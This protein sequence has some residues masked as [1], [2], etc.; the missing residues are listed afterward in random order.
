MHQ[1]HID[2]GCFVDDEQ[3]AVEGVLAIPP[4]AAGP[5]IDFEQAVDGLRLEAG[6]LIHALGRT[7][8]GSTQQEPHALCREYAQDGMDEGCLAYARTS[9]DHQHF[10]GER[11]RDGQSLGF[12]QYQAGPPLDPRDRLVRVNR[13]PGQLA[14]RKLEQ[15]L[16]DS[17]I[18]CRVPGLGTAAGGLDA[19]LPV[20]G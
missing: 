11:Q 18:V 9:G 3:V 5:G 19:I 8:S 14:G 13:G 17:I 16:G 6:G 20:L 15:P 7:A 12:G 1:E 2:H 4:K 10:A